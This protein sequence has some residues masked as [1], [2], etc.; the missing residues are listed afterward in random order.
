ML[1]VLNAASLIMKPQPSLCYSVAIETCSMEQIA[2]LY[3]AVLHSVSFLVTMLLCL[4]RSKQL[5]ALLRPA[6]FTTAHHS[7]SLA[8][9]TG[10]VVDYTF[11]FFKFR[12]RY[13]L[14]KINAWNHTNIAMVVISLF[15]YSWQKHT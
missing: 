10:K 7:N 12:L 4:G 3:S 15:W 1:Y 13:H 2:S 5:L 8:Q 9:L 6:N 14:L 11:I